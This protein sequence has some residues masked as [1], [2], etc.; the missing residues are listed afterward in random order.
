MN[1]VYS[2]TQ[3]ITFT[4]VLTG[5]RDLGCYKDN[6]FAWD[7]SIRILTTDSGFV[8]SECFKNCTVYKYGALVR[9]EPGFMTC[10]CGVIFGRYGL[11]NDWECDD[12]AT[13]FAQR[14]LRIGKSVLLHSL[15]I[16]SSNAEL[17]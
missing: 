14:V 2:L 6:K 16:L 3:V 12:P 8:L 17:I 11:L 15:Y 5:Y 1:E 9:T 7:V 4:N 10:K 13:L